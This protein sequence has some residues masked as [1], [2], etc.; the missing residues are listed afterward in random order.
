MQF[1]PDPTGWFGVKDGEDS[2][3]Q[4][5]SA[6]LSIPSDT[7]RTRNVVDDVQKYQG[8]PTCLR[9]RVGSH[10]ASEIHHAAPLLG[11]QPAIG[12]YCDVLALYRN[13]HLNDYVYAVSDTVGDA[14]MASWIARGGGGIPWKEIHSRQVWTLAEAQAVLGYMPFRKACACISFCDGLV[15]Y[16]G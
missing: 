9:S 10:K 14:S 11:A 1:L 8:R 7:K 12:P 5:S 3:R 2:V 4:S 15:H 6:A 16:S 13:L